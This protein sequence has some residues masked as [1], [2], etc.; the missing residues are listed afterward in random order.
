MSLP[1]TGPANPRVRME[2]EIAS[3]IWP[4]LQPKSCFRGVIIT[5]GAERMPAV[6]TTSR[7]VTA[8]I[9]HP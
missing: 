5:P 1:D 6:T 8:T 7:K 2:S 3:D 4:V 9:T